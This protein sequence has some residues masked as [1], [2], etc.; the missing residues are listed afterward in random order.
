[1]SSTFHTVAWSP[2]IGTTTPNVASFHRHLR[3]VFS[4]CDMSTI[5]VPDSAEIPLLSSFLL[6]SRYGRRAVMAGY[7]YLGGG[8][9]DF[10]GVPLSSRPC[11]RAAWA[12]GR[13]TWLLS[14]VWQLSPVQ[15]LSCLVCLRIWNLRGEQRSR[16][17]TA[18]TILC[19][20][21]WTA[22]SYPLFRTLDSSQLPSLQDPGQLLLGSSLYTT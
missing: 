14:D 16:P 11:Q 17:W 21:P 7:N 4:L 18:H 15:R 12:P 13:R 3:L 6:T 8:F 2:H 1:M 22:H 9:G 5:L 19:S 20:G 10:Q